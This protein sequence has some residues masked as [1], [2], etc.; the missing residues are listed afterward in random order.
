VPAKSPTPSWRPSKPV[1]VSAR[2]AAL[3]SLVRSIRGMRVRV[4]PGEAGDREVQGGAYRQLLR[5]SGS[6]RRTRQF[7]RRSRPSSE[8]V[9]LCQSWWVRRSLADEHDELL[10]CARHRYHPDAGAGSSTV[11]FRGALDAYETLSDPPH[12]DGSTTGTSRL[13]S[14]RPTIIAEPIGSRRWPNFSLGRELF[15][16]ALVSRTV[17][18]G[19]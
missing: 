2:S 12:V 1:R 3:P 8:T 5:S 11:Q 9:V 4:E 7:R 17:G 10:R 14:V 15:P 16:L 18:D 19:H 13:A 6:T